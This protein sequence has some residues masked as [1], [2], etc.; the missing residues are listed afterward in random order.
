MGITAFPVLARILAD[1]KL[2]DTRV[3]MLAISCAAVDDVSAEVVAIVPLVGDEGA[4]R[5]S[6]H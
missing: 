2:M 3:G 1:R 4:H 6:E 5:R